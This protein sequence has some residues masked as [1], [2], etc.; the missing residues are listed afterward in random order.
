MKM[1]TNWGQNKATRAF[2]L[3]TSLIALF[4]GAFACTQPASAATLTTDR[5][6]YPP[7]S[8]VNITGT[9][10][11]SGETVRNH[12]VQLSPTPAEYDTWDVIADES[13]NFATSWFV[14][15]DELIGATL[16]VTAT[17]QS[18]ALS[19]SAIFGDA[20]PPTGTAPVAPPAGGF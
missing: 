3:V 10:F 6:D 8:Y 16:E 20:T 11:G 4:F 17:G 9:G 7:F 14:F 2:H 12:V 15:S 1:R 5:E 19:A 18:S 13:G